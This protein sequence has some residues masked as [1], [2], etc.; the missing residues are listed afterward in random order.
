MPG[1]R[2]RGPGNS[3]TGGIDPSNPVGHGDLR[4]GQIALQHQ[5]FCPFDP[6]RYHVG[7][8]EAAGA[9]RE[10]AR[11]IILAQPHQ[12]RESRIGQSRSQGA[13]MWRSTR[14][15]CQGASPPRTTACFWATRARCRFGK[16]Q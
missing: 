1:P 13:S 9:D 11:E 6:L 8:G 10:K 2:R 3:G 7:V 14:V 4:Q 5:D 12:R 15:S 16:S